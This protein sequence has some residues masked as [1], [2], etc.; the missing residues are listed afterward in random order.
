[1]QIMDYN[2]KLSLPNNSKRQA[3]STERSRSG[4]TLIELLIVISILAVLA[5]ISFAAFRGLT[6]RG[7][8][9]RIQSDLKSIADAYE[10][11][12]SVPNV[13]S[14]ATLFLA[15]DDFSGGV[16]PVNPI[17]G[18]DYCIRT[19]PTVVGNAAPPPSTADITAT[20]ACAG[21]VGNG[22]TAWNVVSASPLGPGTLFFKVCAVDN[23][24]SVVFCIG[25]KQ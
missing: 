5:V 1:M 21:G 8:N 16:L 11:K 10:V 15:G 4:F 18:R 23:D 6:A 7:N 3:I 19:G 13:A 12:R 2:M 22:S 20:G 14:Y 24:V 25:S 9:A 17:T